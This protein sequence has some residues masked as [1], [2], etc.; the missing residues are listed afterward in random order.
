M[1]IDVLVRCIRRKTLNHIN[2]F[3][4]EDMA[5]M[6]N[7]WDMG[8]HCSK[9]EGFG[10]VMLEMAAC[11]VPWAATD[12]TSMSEL[13]KGHGW[14]VPPL[15][16]IWTG[17]NS[18]WALPNEFKIAEAIE[19]AYNNPKKVRRLGRK[20]RKFCLDYDVKKVV[21]RW[22]ELFEEVRREVTS[23]GISEEKDVLFADKLKELMET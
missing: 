16:K 8:L 21:P 9:A 6:Y 19:D 15:T 7:G 4:T 3:V 14:L 13:T 1:R 18:C 5:N 17:V 23:F 11:G 2:A 20:A 12:F 10:I 22:I